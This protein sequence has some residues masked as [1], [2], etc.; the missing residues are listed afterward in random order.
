MSR[1]IRSLAQSLDVNLFERHPIRLTTKGANLLNKV[2]KILHTIVHIEYC[3]KKSSEQ[4]V[5]N[6]TISPCTNIFK[7]CE[8]SRK[9]KEKFSM[10]INIIEA[11]Y[12]EIIFGLKQQCYD[13]S[14]SYS[15]S[16]INDISSEKHWSEKLIVLLPLRH[17]LAE[18]KRIS[19]Q[20]IESFNFISLLIDIYLSQKIYNN[21]LHCPAVTFVKSSYMLIS[22]VTAGFGITIV[23][24]SMYEHQKNE[25]IVV[26]DLDFDIQLETFLLFPQK[27]MTNFGNEQM[28]N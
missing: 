21:I 12:E 19:F 6:I 28:I 7:I 23:P 22:L 1:A 3:F 10:N 27:N 26:H 13:F 11:S 9:Y 20:H 15:T 4:K 24:E 14:F 2:K 25:N 18:L 5:I 8:L 16:S 17:P